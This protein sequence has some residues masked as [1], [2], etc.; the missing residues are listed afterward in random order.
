MTQND[1]DVWQEALQEYISI[2]KY[3]TTAPTVAIEQVSIAGGA[4]G[5][6]AGV[7]RR[8]G[9]RFTV[10]G[11]TWR[12]AGTNIYGIATQV[13][14]SYMRRVFTQVIMI[15]SIAAHTE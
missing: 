15:V 12:F 14:V 9:T 8:Q 13:A 10:N 6:V 3:N 2:A 11:N 4:A 1:T 5:P 7:V